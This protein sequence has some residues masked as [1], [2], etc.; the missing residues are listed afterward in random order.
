[1]DDK[2]GARVDSR[3]RCRWIDQ[4]MGGVRKRLTYPGK[5]AGEGKR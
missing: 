1:M 5:K 4:G 2:E 3:Y